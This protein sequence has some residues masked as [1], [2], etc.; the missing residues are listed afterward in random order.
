MRVSDNSN[1]GVVRDSMSRSRNRLEDLQLQNS[2]LKKLN[3]PSDDPVGS[4]KILEVRTDK[5]NNEQFQSNARL[6]QSFLENSDAALQDLSEIVMRAKE[7][8]IGQSSAA[9]STPESRMGVAEEVNQLFERAIGTANRRL[10]DR[11]LFGG[12]KNTTHPVDA[13]GNYQGDSGE[14]MLEIGREV[15]IGMNIPGYQVFNTSPENAQDH[16]AIE[17]RNPSKPKQEKNAEPARRLAAIDSEEKPPV[18]NVNIFDELKSLRI[19]LLTGD[20]TAI[21]GTLERF[22]DLLAKVVSTRAKIGSRVQ[23]IE[24]N[25]TSMERHNVSNAQL[26]STI[27]DADMTQIV[28][29]LAKEETVFKSSLASSKHLIQPTLLEFLR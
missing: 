29:D 23:G 19:G 21:R 13:E 14:M 2:T 10:G 27:E 17:L 4:A 28:S 22:D 3:K 18:P 16:Q 12:F 6:A 7:I 26:S 24:G 5:V 9:S 1:F 20:Q 11:Y 8:A 25:I 15:Y